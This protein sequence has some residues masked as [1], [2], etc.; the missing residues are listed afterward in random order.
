MVICLD[1]SIHLHVILI[2]YLTRLCALQT[3]IWANYIYKNV[4]NL[5]FN[6]I[7]MF[8]PH[9]ADKKRIL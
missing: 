4:N 2:I 5:W 3:A 7:N 8:S 1:T 9:L 6:L